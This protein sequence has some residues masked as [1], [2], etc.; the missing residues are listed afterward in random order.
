MGAPNG[1]GPR[2]IAVALQL[3]RTFGPENAVIYRSDLVACFLRLT[4][5]FFAGFFA[6]DFPDF[7]PALSCHAVARPLG[8]RFRQTWGVRRASAA[9]GRKSRRAPLF[10]R[11]PF[12]S[13]SV[14]RAG[15]TTGDRAYAPTFQV[16]VHKVRTNIFH[17]SIPCF[18]LSKDMKIVKSADDQDS[19]N[20]A[21]AKLNK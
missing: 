19:I 12:F 15:A 20:K 13:V 3:P 1:R 10:C 4:F 2:G 7:C 18:V 21:V 16:F 6:F 17:F 9:L 8:G 11:G 14:R 5:P